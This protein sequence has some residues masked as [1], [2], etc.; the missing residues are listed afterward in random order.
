MRA[1]RA[2]CGAGATGPAAWMRRALW[3]W[4]GIPVAPVHPSRLGLGGGAVGSGASG[5]AAGQP[6]QK[7]SARSVESQQ[8]VITNYQQTL[9]SHFV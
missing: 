6:T 8:F 2:R 9:S 1:V 3:A 4:G 7:P 5:R